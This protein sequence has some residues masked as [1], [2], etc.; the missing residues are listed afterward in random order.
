MSTI[1]ERIFQGE[2]NRFGEEEWFY[3]AREGVGG[4]YSCKDDAILALHHFIKYCIDNGF[5][6][7]RDAMENIFARI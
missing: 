4:P 5:T 2:A 1:S 7:G 3:R 6:G